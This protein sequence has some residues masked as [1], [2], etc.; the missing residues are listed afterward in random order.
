MRRVFHL[1]TGRKLYGG[2]YQVA[3]IL[4]HTGDAFEHHLLCDRKSDLADAVPESTRVHRL[5][6]RG[7]LDPA[8]G[9]H[10]W[11]ILRQHPGALLHIHSR[12]G[13]DLWG[14]LA[15]RQVGVPFLVS[16]RVDN[17]ESPRL[18]RWKLKRAAAVIGISEAIC[19]VLKELG[20]PP[21]VIRMV[22][23]GVDTRRFAYTLPKCPLPADLRIPPDVPTIGMAAQFI[24]RKGHTDLVD[25]AP[26]ILQRH[27]RTRFLLLGKGKLEP[28]IRSRVRAAGLDSAFC[29]AGF[30]DDLPGILPGLDLLVHPA[31][32]EGL[33]VAVL[34]AMASGRAVVA[35]RAGGLPEI[36]FPGKTGHLFPPGD[37]IA[38]AARVNEVLDDPRKAREMGSAARDWIV[39]NASLEQTAAGNA[40][41]YNQI[42]DA[43]SPDHPFA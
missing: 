38:L 37:S 25:A 41:I 6:L 3:G 36:V 1:E 39:R 18:L 5:A 35:A 16:R 24:P 34:Q 33:G 26:A 28:A 2:A 10:L 9:F 22:R 12:R 19:R 13:A 27:P 4:Q 17:R 11:R 29:F 14:P 32:L 8:L 42:F 23:S 7:E 31:H 15:A 40:A 30:R 43:G 21:G 20:I